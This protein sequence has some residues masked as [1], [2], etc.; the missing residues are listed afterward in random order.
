VQASGQVAVLVSARGDY[1]RIPFQDRRDARNDGTSVFRQLSP[2]L[3]VTFTPSA[4]WRLYGSFGA[5]FRA[6]AALELACASPDASCP[7]P[8]SLGA[9]PP[10]RPVVAW[11]RELGADWASPAGAAVTLSLFRSDV[12]DEIA[13]VASS[14][15]SGYFQNIPRTRREG[16]EATTRLPLPHAVTLRGSYSYVDATYRSHATLASTLAGNDVQPGNVFP[17]SPRHRGSLEV[18]TVRALGP[19]LLS[20]IVTVRAVSSQYLR[21]DEA[22]Q[23]E[24]MA[25]YGVADFRLRGERGRLSSELAL[26]N[27]LNR[28]YTLY[29]VYADNPKGVPGT[30]ASG[31]S[32]ERFFTPAY[33]RV[34]SISLAIRR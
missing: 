23:R 5:G 25:G 8:F 32:V 29:G 31:E 18:E 10:L 28:R 22:N 9:D 16:L 12:H 3:G 17:L 34:A 7:L 15:A 33:P 30:P 2:M 24:P 19:A 20:A 1:V 21:G 11:N 4:T 13:F 27:V 14:S 26:S 6:P